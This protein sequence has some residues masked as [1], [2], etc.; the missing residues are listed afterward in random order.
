M[1]NPV[2]RSIFL[3]NKLRTN[4]LQLYENEARGPRNGNSRVCLSGRR[5]WDINS[6]TGLLKAR[7]ELTVFPFRPPRC[8]KSRDFA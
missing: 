2:V 1:I 7:G 3:W 6:C 5:V 4:I 8:E